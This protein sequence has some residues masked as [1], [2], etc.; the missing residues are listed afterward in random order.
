M[1]ELE[2]IHAAVFRRGYQLAWSSGIVGT[3]TGIILVLGNLGDPSHLGV[4]MAVSLLT[5]LYGG[6]L[7]EFGFRVLQP[8]ATGGD[9][10]I[11]TDATLNAGCL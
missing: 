6:I 11:P 4:G 1:F 7:A 10:S 2:A 8:S 5:L 9:G 3:L